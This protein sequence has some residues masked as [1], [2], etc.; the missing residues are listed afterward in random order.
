MNAFQILD[1]V[2]KNPQTYFCGEK[3]LRMVWTLLI[4]YE[5]GITSCGKPAIFSDFRH[6]NTWLAKELNFSIPTCR[7]WRNMIEARTA[8]DEEAFDRFFELL[9]RYR[10]ET[11]EPGPLQ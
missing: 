8:T 11:S 3:S 10:K 4:G 1:F 9:D 6:F 7:G 2:R 5:I